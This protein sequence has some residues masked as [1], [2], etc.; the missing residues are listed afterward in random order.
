MM[1]A[2]NLHRADKQPDWEKIA[3]EERNWWQRLAAK[4]NGVVTPANL[5]TFTGNVLMG[6]GLVA[7]SRGNRKLGLGL[8]GGARVAD[9]ADGLLAELTGTKSPLGEAFDAGSDKLQTVTASAVFTHMG[10]L[11]RSSAALM[12]AEQAAITAC[13]VA[14]RSR[15]IALHPSRAGKLSMFAGW[16]AIVGYSARDIMRSA[17]TAIPAPARHV[18][19][20]LPD[21][22]TV[23]SLALG[24]KA[25]DGYV[26]D[27]FG[28]PPPS[29]DR[30]IEVQ[31]PPFIAEPLGE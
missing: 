30:T 1:R 8:V 13:G 27:T 31:L 18:L 29:Y 6:C 24:A 14:A 16:G 21:A 15:N 26:E 10:I 28:T 17:D 7:I 9:L 20:H 2:M 19:E 11:P 5:A 3:P 22:L 4:T 23:M 25:I 12:L